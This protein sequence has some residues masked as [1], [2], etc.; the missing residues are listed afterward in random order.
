MH[1]HQ[2]A[3]ADLHAAMSVYDHVRSQ[4]DRRRKFD[5][6][7]KGPQRAALFDPYLLCDLD[8]AIRDRSQAVV[9]STTEIEVYCAREA[10]TRVQLDASHPG[11]GEA[12]E[13]PQLEPLIRQ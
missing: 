8:G 2:R 7:A 6:A 3:L 9:K 5:G 10:N 12:P 4:E 11:A 1:C 13:K